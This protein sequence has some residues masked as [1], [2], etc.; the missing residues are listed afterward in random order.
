MSCGRRYFYYSFY[1][2]SSVLPFRLTKSN[3]VVTGSCHLYF[4]ISIYQNRFYL[5]YHKSKRFL[6]HSL[7]VT[8]TESKPGNPTFY[9]SI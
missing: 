9:F 2:G 8:E 4:Y 7:H 3:R 6:Y 5:A 1:R